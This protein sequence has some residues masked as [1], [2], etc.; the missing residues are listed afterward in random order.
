MNEEAIS[1]KIEGPI[2][3]DP[4][5]LHE[6]ISILSD[7][8]SII[9]QSYLVLTDKKRMSRSDRL[10]YQILASYAK[11]GSY[12]QELIIACAAAFPLLVNIT[13]QLTSSYIWNTTK[14]AFNFLKTVIGL[15]REGKEIKMSGPNNQGIIVITSPGS[16]PI[17]INQT[18]FN[19]A[20][21]SEEHY[22]R[23]SEHIGAGHIDQINATDT[24]T[25]GILLTTKEKKL[26]NPETKIE[27]T[28]VEF[29]CN[30]FD[31][32]KEKLAGKL[33]VED[34]QPL[35]PREYN[36]SLIGEQDYIPYIMA[37]TKPKVIFKCLPE[38]EI[39]TTGSKNISRLQAISIKDVAKLS[40]K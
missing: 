26:F 33:R 27:D 9:D 17:N 37:M 36:F 11:T 2:I 38:I 14:D 18:I 7:F 10:N 8:H 4:Y 5:P 15:R 23:M 20:D 40:K 21:K 32:N 19:V 16:Q 24:K 6:I 12:I 3:R 39:H 28:P 13:P 31:F 22:K 25:E 1:L 30:V 34:G 35:P 29:I